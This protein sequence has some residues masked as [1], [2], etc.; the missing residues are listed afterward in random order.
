LARIGGLKMTGRDLPS[1]QEWIAP[2]IAVVGSLHMDF[3][4]KVETIPRVGETVLGSAFQRSP[5]GKGA[6]Q[7]V[8]AAKLGADVV[9]IGRVGADAVGREL[10][11]AV[12]AQGIDGG[13]VLEDEGTYTGLALILVDEEGGNIIAVASGADLNCCTEDI[14]RAEEAITASTV[15]LT[16]LEIPLPVVE[17]A[18]DVAYGEGVRVILN[19][20]P[21]HDLSDHLLKKVYLLTPNETEA[22]FLTGIQIRGLRTADMAAERLLARGVDNVVM[23]LGREGALIATKD[24]TVHVQGVDVQA[25]DTTGAGDAFCGALAVAIAT[26]KDL[27]DAVTYA[28][29]AGALTTTKIGA[30]EALPTREDLERFMKSRQ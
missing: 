27:R 11:E 9:L 25:V 28:N 1:S 2:K 3:I 18:V 16:Q 29:Y 7:A 21:A 15:L 4:V 5:G 14:K 10:L 12:K 26:G 20:A 24:G 23:T 30:Q 8:A 13:Y 19:P 6:N 22:E 17:Y